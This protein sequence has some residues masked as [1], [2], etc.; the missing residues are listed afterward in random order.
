MFRP[1]ADIHRNTIPLIQMLF[2][3]H[4]KTKRCDDAKR[5]V[6]P[7]PTCRDIEELYNGT[8]SG[9]SVEVSSPC[10]IAGLFN[11]GFYGKG[12]HSRSVPNSLLL[13]SSRSQCDET[14]EFKE[15]LSL[16]LEE[17]FYLSFC[18]KVLRVS[19]FCGEQLGWQCFLKDALQV[20]SLFLE[21]LAA[22]IYLKSKGWVVKSGMKFG[23][24][25]RKSSVAE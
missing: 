21:S 11:N 13:S 19:N 9:I 14:Y 6:Q 5:N 7:F 25:F 1:H 3:P 16:G 12:S 20:N 4:V 15:T 10:G 24:D 17:A 23:G 2:L 8:F 18:L 22:Y